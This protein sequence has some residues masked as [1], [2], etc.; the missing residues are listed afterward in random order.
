MHEGE[1][2]INILFITLLDIR[3]INNSGIYEDLLREFYKNGHSVYIISP[4]ER[5]NNEHTH[6]IEKNNYKIIKVRTG[7]IQKTNLIEKGISTILLETQFINAIKKYFY[8]VKFDLILYSTPPIT[9]VKPIKFIKKRDNAKSYLLL[10]DIFPQNAV[11]IGILSKSG[12]RGIIYKY[13]RKKEKRLYALS[14]KIGCMSQANLDYII[15]NN[16]EINPEKTELC[17]NSIEP[18]DVSITETERINIREKYSLP[19]DKKIFVYGGNL[20]KPQGVPFIIECLR[21]CKDI[22]NAFFLIIGS[23]T[24]YVRLKKFVE[25][26]NPTNVKLLDA[27]PKDEYDKMISACN[28]GLIFL[29]HRFTIPNFPSRMLSYMQAKLPVLAAT[30]SNTDIGKIIESGRFG[31]WCTSDNIQHFAECVREICISQTV[32]M[33]QAGWEYLNENYTVDKGYTIITS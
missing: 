26:E 31:W 22:E 30:D 15:K 11:D 5:R 17:P 19:L 13:F 3:D 18:H 33:G 28:V 29:D 10:K 23:G 20:G 1:I 24:E 4:V 8:D 7:N 27:L 32:E 9:L 16:T 25:H 14:D 2:S 6:V 21:K 12:I